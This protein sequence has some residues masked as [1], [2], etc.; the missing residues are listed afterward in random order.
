MVCTTDDPTDDLKYHQAIAASGLATQVFPAFR[1]DKSLA[2]NDAVKFNAWIDTLAAA[3][4]VEINN[5]AAFF[6]RRCSSGMNTS[7]LMAAG[8]RTTA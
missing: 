2:V 7:T 1:P 4:N 3:S 5:F 6:G 8:Y